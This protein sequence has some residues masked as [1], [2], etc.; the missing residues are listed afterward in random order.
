MTKDFDFGARRK[1]KIKINGVEREIVNFKGVVQSVKRHG[2]PIESHDG[3]SNH[4]YGLE[5]I[6][7]PLIT[8]LDSSRKPVNKTFI[9]HG[10]SPAVSNKYISAGIILDD[11]PYKRLH[12]ALY[13]SVYEVEGLVPREVI[14]NYKHDYH[15]NEADDALLD[16]EPVMMHIPLWIEDF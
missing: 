13:L 2:D 12:E 4:I 6:V 5:L 8:S 3:K 7:Q 15:D 16:L 14:R 9:F 1:V 10:P 11:S